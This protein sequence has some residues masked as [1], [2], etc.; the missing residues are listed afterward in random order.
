M[1]QGKQGNRARKGTGGVRH[2]KINKGKQAKKIKATQ[3]LVKVVTHKACYDS[4]EQHGWRLW[5]KADSQGIWIH[6]DDV[7]LLVRY[8]H[9]ESR[10]QG[11]PALAAESRMQ[12]VPVPAFA[13]AKP[14]RER[15]ERCGAAEQRSHGDRSIER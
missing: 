2:Q 3:D 12:G 8:L 10:M 11:V 5:R 7:A 6:V 13:A 14:E 1:A 9:E 4:S 15:R